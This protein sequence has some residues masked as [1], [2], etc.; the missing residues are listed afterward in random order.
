M[1]KVYE[2]WGKIEQAYESS[3]S[4]CKQNALAIFFGCSV[5]DG[6]SPGK[7]MKNFFHYG[8]VP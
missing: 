7:I 4:A 2:N 8:N 1:C 5:C 6:N 3:V